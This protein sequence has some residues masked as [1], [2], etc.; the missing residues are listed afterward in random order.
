[1]QEV[2]RSRPVLEPIDRMSEIIFGLLMALTFTGTMS[3][4]VAGGERV[5]SVLMAALGCNI[6]WGIVDAVMFVLA[7]VVERARHNSFV[8]SVRALPMGEAQ[9]VFLENLPAEAR[10]V[11]DDKEVI[12]FLT[13]LREQPAQPARRLIGTND[14]KAA[15][16]IFIL[17]VLSTLPPSLPFLFIDDLHRA[18]RISNGVALVM[19]FLIGAKLGNYV[20]GRAWPIAFAMASIGAVLVAITIALGG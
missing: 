6:A 13:R 17:V 12:R 5:P 19:L 4:S 14:L 3:A 11:M 20:G 8:T 7:T 15:F 1:M 9:Q 10:R 2:E 16:L 18:M